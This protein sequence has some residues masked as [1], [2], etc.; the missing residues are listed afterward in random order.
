MY[1]TSLIGCGDDALIFERTRQRSTS[2]AMLFK[3]YV[4]LVTIYYYYYFLSLS[5]LTTALF[6][7]LN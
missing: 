4:L 7:L 1:D 2:L 3:R 6:E 5:Q